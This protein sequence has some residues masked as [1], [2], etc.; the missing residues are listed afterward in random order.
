MTERHPNVNSKKLGLQFG[1]PYQ[2]L[3]IHEFNI[4][5]LRYAGDRV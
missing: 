1:G 5:K 4:V 3:G 2:V